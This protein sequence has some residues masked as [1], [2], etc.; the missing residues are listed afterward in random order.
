MATQDVLAGQDLATIAGRVY[1]DTSYFRELAALND[2]DIFSPAD[3]V[4]TRIEVPTQAEIES[5]VESA[6][7]TAIDTAALDLSTI[8][9]PA[10]L[11]A[12]QLIE[13]LL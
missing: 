12:Q 8:R 5:L 13:W 3:I 10:S 4:G 6:F 7:E 2:L 9:G 1:G 11:S